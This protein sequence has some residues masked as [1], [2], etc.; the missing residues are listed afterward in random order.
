MTQESGIQRALGLFDN[1]PSKLAQAM[2]EGVLRQHVENW[3]KAGRVPPDRAP[4]LEQLCDHK[5]RLWDL[6][7]SDWHQI[8]PA[9]IGAEGAPPV[10]GSDEEAPP[11]S[12]QPAATA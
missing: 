6:R 1:K 11:P 12:A 9:L 10:P 7:P 3:L 2:G 4:A 5:V 8:W